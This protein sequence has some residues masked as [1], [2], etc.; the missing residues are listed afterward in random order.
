MLCQ[1]ASR[2]LRRALLVSDMLSD[3]SSA[4]NS[5]ENCSP[6][7]ASEH[8]RSQPILRKYKYLPW[9][10]QLNNSSLC[11]LRLA[12]ALRAYNMHSDAVASGREGTHASC[13]GKSAAVLLSH[14]PWPAVERKPVPSCP[15]VPDCPYACDVDRRSASVS[16]VRGVSA[17]MGGALRAGASCLF[18]RRGAR[19]RLAVRLAGAVV[20][21]EVLP[22]DVCQAWHASRDPTCFPLSP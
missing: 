2:G 1:V 16:S 15:L 11:L 18:W 7:S 5:P 6:S 12:V 13:V 4:P 19:R 10:L 8:D 14:S 3:V 21:A 9:P 22:Q 17:I 20:C